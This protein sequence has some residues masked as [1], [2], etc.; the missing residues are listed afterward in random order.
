MIDHLNAVGGRF[1]GNRRGIFAKINNISD[2]WIN[3]R[4]YSVGFVFFYIKVP[5]IKADVCSD[6][7]DICT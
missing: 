2:I 6:T 3:T 7:N 5:H 4:L 1:H